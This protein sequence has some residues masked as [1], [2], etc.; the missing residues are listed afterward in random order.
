MRKIAV[1]RPQPAL[2]EPRSK[3]NQEILEKTLTLDPTHPEY[4]LKYPFEAI[5]AAAGGTPEIYP[6]KHAVAVALISGPQGRYKKLRFL[7][8]KFVL[9]GAEVT[10]EIH[11][12]KDDLK[13]RVR[14]ALSKRGETQ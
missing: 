2:V 1:D 11:A 10:P 14:L 13:F 4:P 7:E 9:K 5:Y 3:V 12:L 6:F 8:M